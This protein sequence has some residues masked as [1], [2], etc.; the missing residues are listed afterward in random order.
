[1]PCKTISADQQ[2]VDDD[3]LELESALEE[4]AADTTVDAAALEAELAGKSGL[5]TLRAKLK[6]SAVNYGSQGLPFLAAVQLDLERREPI[7]LQELFLAWLDKGNKKWLNP[8]EGLKKLNEILFKYRGNSAVLKPFVTLLQ[9]LAA[10]GISPASFVTYVILPRMQED[11]HWKKWPDNHLEALQIIAGV[12]LSAKDQPP[13]DREHLGSPRF[14]LSKDVVLV[15]YIGRPLAQHRLSEL[16]DRQ[17]LEAYQQAWQNISLNNSLS[18]YFMRRNVLHFI[19]AMSGRIDL[20]QLAA[21]IGQLPYIEQAFA[22]AFPQDAA[23]SAKIEAKIEEV[24]LFD[25]D[26]GSALRARRRQGYHGLDFIVEI[27]AYLD[28]VKGL[29]EKPTGVYLCAYYARLLRRYKD[30][31]LAGAISRLVRVIDDQGGM[32]IYKW[33]TR[34]LLE[35]TKT[36]MPAY[37]DFIEA[38][39]GCDP[40][41]PHIYM[42]FRDEETARETQDV[43]NDA[44]R[45]GLRHIFTGDKNEIISYKD[46]LKA[47]MQEHPEYTAL[48]T[49]YKQQL[50]AGQDRHWTAEYTK[51]LD[52][53][54]P[55]QG[56]L[57][58]PLLRLVI[59]GIGT[60]FAHTSKSAS[61]TQLFNNYAVVQTQRNPAARVKFTMPVKQIGRA[62]A[63][64]EALARQQV[65]L[66]LIWKIWQALHLAEPAAVN[67]VLSYINKWSLALE[68]PREKTFAEKV[69]LEKKL[70]ET[71]DE[72]TRKNLEKDLAQ[73]NRI[74]GAL[75]QKKQQYAVIM[76]EFERLNNEQKFITAL[77]LAGALGKNDRDFAALALKLLL[78]RYS[79]EE[80]VSS[81]LNFLKEDISVDVLTY[82]QF[83]Y[84][85]NLLD[86]LYFTLRQDAKIQ[87]A[88]ATDTVLQKI[89]QPYLVTKKK[90]VTGDA[91]DS[92]AKKMAE[93]AALQ[94]ERAKWQGTL[95]K[96]ENKSG[97]YF[98]QLEIQ[99]SKAF[100]DAYYGDMGGICLSAQPQL[101]L[102]PAFFVQRLVDH[103]DQE[104][105]GI[106][107]LY[108]SSQGFSS[109]QTQ[110]QHFWQAFAFNPLKSFLEHCTLEQQLYL[111]LQYR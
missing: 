25:Y 83:T 1:M 15:R 77:I 107:A 64:K 40:E 2:I 98:H 21:L 34:K 61:F 92:A 65:N 97:A 110:A 47:F 4:Q 43:L 23:K 8:Y 96:L 60:G 62:S 67:N 99:T 70:Q 39:A 24:N 17:L 13:F 63:D 81:R 7:G 104:I 111:Y 68:E 106:A 89:L 12:I 30:P 56:A 10:A 52:S 32:Y 6:A 88:L 49:D 11:Y 38:N 87:A 33:H 9:E 19:Y 36:E 27:N 3:D 86:T 57:H 59:R 29:L 41:Y 48:I 105:I 35:K 95:D 94:A 72:D 103:T 51:Q 53:L 85:L 37:I 74:I 45:L 26:I 75:A 100:I 66:G 79:G 58:L 82:P 91:L 93:Y 73:N 54:S 20:I 101:I 78:V 76:Q 50:L 16:R 71:A 108:L 5:K 46:L 31:V 14:R 18:V 44:E 80:S 22:G 102:K 42:L 28:I 109:S 84:L 55:D 90:Q 69:A